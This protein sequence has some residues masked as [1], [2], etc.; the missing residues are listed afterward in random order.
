SRRTDF[1]I[2]DVPGAHI[3][4][5]EVRPRSPA[6]GCEIEVGGLTGRVAL[7]LRQNTAYQRTTT[8]N[9]F[10]AGVFDISVQ[11]NP[12]QLIV[13]IFVTSASKRNLPDLNGHEGIDVAEGLALVV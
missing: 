9:R 12:G 11:A 5:V 3:E 1:G 2:D 13:Q 6:E 8:C 10:N 7:Y 4:C